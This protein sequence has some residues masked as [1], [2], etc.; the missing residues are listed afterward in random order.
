MNKIGKVI[1]FLSSYSPL[2]ILIITLNYGITDIMDSII[3]LRKLA[4]ININDM[5]LYVL[6]ILIIVPI[7]ILIF[8]LKVSNDY[9][10]T[11]R[12]IGVSDGNDKVVD[13]VLAYIV[14][15]ITT[16]FVNLK[17]YDINILV[18]GILIQILLCYLYCKSNMLYINPVLNICFG[19]N[20]FIVNTNKKNLI[21]L[22]KNTDKAYSVK[23]EISEKGFKNIKL[24]CFS[25]GIYILK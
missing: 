12:I 5:I 1:M 24:N 2:Y 17:D 13:Y 19:Y 25:N 15:F 22:T 9:T 8:A 21:I 10:E 7:I 18:T 16:D 23:E 11:I 4:N 20:I 6:V 3:K 14:S